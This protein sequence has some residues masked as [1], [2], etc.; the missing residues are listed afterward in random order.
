MELGWLDVNLI[1]IHLIFFSEAKPRL[2]Y[3]SMDSE[4]NGIILFVDFLL[5]FM[6]LGYSFICQ[7]HANQNIIY[8]K[9]FFKTYRNQLER[10]ELS[11]IVYLSYLIY[12]E[13]KLFKQPHYFALLFSWHL[14]SRHKFF[15][16]NIIGV[17]YS[18]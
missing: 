13:K 15:K 12:F 5:I 1:S 17:I 14:A 6:I 4:I 18:T 10:Q 3:S 16:N 7:I 9:N 11:L 8:C 2:Y